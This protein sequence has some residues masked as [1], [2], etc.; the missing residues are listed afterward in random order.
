VVAAVPEPALVVLIERRVGLEVG[1]RQVIQ[2]HLEA[3]V[4]QIAPATRQMIKQRL[5]VLQ[6]P[7]M[8]SVEQVRIG[9]PVIGAE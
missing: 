3:H 7:S 9:E 1:A 8:T 4:E 2:Q 6:E 5:L